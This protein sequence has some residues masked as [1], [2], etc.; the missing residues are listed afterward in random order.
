VPRKITADAGYFS[1]K[2]VAGCEELG[3]DPHIAT[4]RR[5]RDEPLPPPLKG[6]RPGGLTA[7]EQMARKLGTKAGALV[8]AKRKWVVEPV[9]GQIKQARGFR[10]FLRRGVEKVREEWA[11]ICMTHNLLKLHGARAMA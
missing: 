2:N 6:R 1:E 11:L 8:Y 3:I 7:K 5:K 10:Q 4:G 9:F